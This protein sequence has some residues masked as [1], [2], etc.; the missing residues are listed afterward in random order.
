[1]Q[2]R[3]QLTICSLLF[4]SVTKSSSATLP[5]SVDST[6]ATAW[7]CPQASPPGSLCVVVYIPIFPPVPGATAAAM[8][9]SLSVRCVRWKQEDHGSSA[10]SS[11][12][13]TEAGC[14]VDNVV[15]NHNKSA[16][17]GSSNRSRTSLAEDN[18]LVVCRCSAAGLFKAISPAP[19]ISYNK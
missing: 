4:N 18:T 15:W 5:N 14:S 7:T 11:G 6:A 2:L 19:R 12:E 1:M 8:I 17:E 10:G 9:D 13:W 3:L 16:G